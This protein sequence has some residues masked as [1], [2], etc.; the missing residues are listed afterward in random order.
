MESLRKQAANLLHE[1][2]KYRRWLAVFLCL[3]VL[4]T[5]GTVAALMMKGQAMNRKQKVLECHLSV[6][7]HTAECYET[8]AESGEKMLVCGYADYVVHTHMEECMDEEGN[9]VCQLPEVE[10]HTH[11]EGCFEDK[12]VLVCELEETQGH[13]H[14]E[15]CRK[16]ICSREESQG[17]I[18]TES[19]RKLVCAQEENPGH[20]H[21][22]ACRTLTQGALKCASIEEGHEH[23]QDCYEQ[24]ES[25]TCGLEE[26]AGSHVHTESCYDLY[27]CGLAEGADAHIHTEK[28]YNPY[29]CGLKEGQGAHA[30][31]LACYEV[32]KVAVCGKLELHTHVKEGDN[33][34]YDENG[35]LICGIPELREHVHGEDCFRIVEEARE[36]ADQDGTH[37]GETGKDETDKADVLTG[38]TNDGAAAGQGADGADKGAGEAD[39][40]A[41]GAD[42]DAAE[43]DQ[44]ADGADKDAAE[45]DQTA[46]GADK[47]A[48]EA[49]QT[50]G[51]T[52][53]PADRAD[54]ESGSDTA[55]SAADGDKDG[56]G[57]D[58]KHSLTAGGDD[59]T[60]T[61]TYGDDAGIP[62][63]AELK[64]REIPEGTDEYDKYYQEMVAA[65]NGEGAETQEEGETDSAEGDSGSVSENEIEVSFV[66][67]F[68]ITFMVNGEKY[69][70]KAPVDIRVSYKDAVEL[71]EDETASVVHFA[72]EGT[73]VLEAQV[74]DTEEGSDFTFTQSSFS[75]SGTGV[76]RAPA[77]GTLKYSKNGCTITVTYDKK[78]IRANA[79]LMVEEIVDDGEEGGNSS[80]RKYLNN[81]EGAIKE[82]KNN[83]DKDQ[84]AEFARVFKVSVVDAETGKSID[85]ASV[86]V[87][88][89]LD[90]P[91]V[92]SGA[93]VVAMVLNTE[94]SA[95]VLGNQDVAEG[96]SISTFSGTQTFS[97]ASPNVM[98]VMMTEEVPLDEGQEGDGGSG[99]GSGTNTSV[100]QYLNADTANAWQVVDQKFEGNEPK[101]KTV[102]SNDGKVRVQKN[103]IPT[104]VEN[105]F[106]VYLSID[107]KETMEEFFKQDIFGCM[108][109]GGNNKSLGKF[110]S[111]GEL[112]GSP[113]GISPEPI[114]DNSGT[115]TI[116]YKGEILVEKFKLYWE[117]NNVYIYVN[118]G[119]AAPDPSKPY[120]LLQD[121]IKDGSGREY[122]L[123]LQDK[124]MAE[125]LIQTAKA[126]V[127]L[128][129]ITDEL[130]DFI[131]YMEVMGGDYTNLPAPDTDGK[132]VWYPSPK[133]NPDKDTTT[134]TGSSGL[135]KEE[136]WCK[137]IAELVYKVKLNVSDPDFISQSKSCAGCCVTKGIIPQNDLEN[138]EAHSCEVNKKATVYYDGGEVDFQKPYVRGLLYDHEFTKKKQ[139]KDGN[140]LGALPGAQFT[141]IGTDGDGKGKTYP[142]TSDESGKVLFKNMPWGTYTI[143]ETVVP[144]GY[145]KSETPIPSVELC[146][147]ED[148]D[149]ISDEGNELPQNMIQPGK[150][151]EV[152]NIKSPRIVL[153]KV[154]DD[155][156][157]AG[158]TRPES[159]E[160]TF[161]LTYK[162]DA[163]TNDNGQTGT[164]VKSGEKEIILKASA[165]DPQRPWRSE[166]IV[167]PLT[168]YDIE[169]R[170]SSVPEKYVVATPEEGADA[171]I[172]GD[173]VVTEET[174]QNGETT[175]A[176]KVYTITNK[177]KGQ[178]VQILKIAELK[179]E[180][181][182]DV[183]LDGAVFQV[184][185]KNP[186]TEKDAKL[187]Y[188]WSSKPGKDRQKGVIFE[189]ELEIGTYWLKET[190]S[191]ED[192]RIL[193]NLVKIEVEIDEVTVEGN[194]IT[195]D[196]TN[197]EI[198]IIKIADKLNAQQ[199]L[200]LKKAS[201]IGEDG[202]AVYL[203]NA[204]FKVY[205]QDPAT[206]GI[207]PIDTWISH[208]EAVDGVDREGVIHV[209]A[210]PVGTY[211]LVETSAPDGYN[212]LTNPIVI[213]VHSTGV[214]MNGAKDP[215]ENGVYVI[216]ISNSA[217]FELPETGST[218]TNPYTV[219]GAMLAATAAFLMYG[220]SMRRRKS[221][222][223]S[224]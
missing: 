224:K 99:S 2:K 64:V 97:A 28:C 100:D 156:D 191:P 80:Y 104:G 87:T 58:K 194:G 208:T 219:G 112:N 113:K 195:I 180:Y 37:K 220:Y 206:P 25:I 118:F 198:S 210:L 110:V 184:Y 186:D 30:H 42:K 34:C 212:L 101:N 83:K 38:E 138:P 27:G 63:S 79:K 82:K 81:S 216:E 190:V 90:T 136:T 20:V 149:L 143:E 106:Y 33:S 76:F 211:W 77:R 127:K 57:T 185:D 55:E 61:V 170:E 92:A 218:G 67:F 116:K 18:H 31:S 105:E 13:I 205:D 139:D 199:V 168:A 16:L 188:T 15:E 52:D 179:D 48:A 89:S 10:A 134:S 207:E 167:I 146:Y 176:I 26:G 73:E 8:D 32:R 177:I 7:E 49:D 124:E 120:F 140:D 222:R 152:V 5:S 154:W 60:V 196:K 12:R 46:D 172:A 223:R 50:D 157:N 39:Q 160:I 125:I 119:N 200:I 166:P 132:L 221:E 164:T 173:A 72:K 45:A 62:E 85:T 56:A 163:I 144:D 169:C 201:E 43:A 88:V 161:T 1:Q 9:V 29:G 86:D 59:Y 21:T 107:T 35:S 126:S 204:V 40:T 53:K 122:V 109:A 182:Q 75:V 74:A 217:G 213:T 203:E 171:V 84:K 19:C 133:S 175:E 4:V 192:Y 155:N 103:V 94:D 147:T 47:D 96:Q 22:D 41:G 14:T 209:G 93:G 108:T 131:E 141:A 117:A 187:L 121:Q 142:A 111:K 24:T 23:N 70:P 215:A 69:E 214:N 183:Y 115:F 91:V 71:G 193:D 159:G 17:H 150:K 189:E 65:V 123:D 66:R 95:V 129:K 102:Y 44:T 54:E 148:K 51:G 153:E 130:G 36:E 197:P 135:K 78:A 151:A 128:E 145:E 98:A 11:E 162:I 114:Y 178:K 174:I 3:A 158:N 202:K 137:N 181:G 68:D 165:D 6:H